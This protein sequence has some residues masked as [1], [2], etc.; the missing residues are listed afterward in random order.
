MTGWEIFYLLL[1]LVV[2]GGL[3]ATIVI[4]AIRFD[5]KRRGRP[6]V[7]EKGDPREPFHG[8]DEERPARR[9]GR[10]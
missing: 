1:A 10:K 7:R 6:V 8:G 2:F 4:H 9:S 5:R 3:F